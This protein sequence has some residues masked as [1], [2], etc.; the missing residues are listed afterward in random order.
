MQPLYQLL[1]PA[2]P[3]RL[4]F[5]AAGT[6]ARQDVKFPVLLNQLHPYRVKHKRQRLARKS[7]SIWLRRPRGVPTR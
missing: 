2:A 6:A 5:I 4:F 1:Q 3:H 7:F